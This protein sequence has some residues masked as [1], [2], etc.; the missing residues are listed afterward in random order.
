MGD[1]S[2]LEN[3]YTILSLCGSALRMCDMVHIPVKAAVDAMIS[4]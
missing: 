4:A 1:P 2:Q 3:P